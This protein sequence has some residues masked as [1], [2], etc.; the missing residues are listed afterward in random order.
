MSRKSPSQSEERYVPEAAKKAETP[1]AGNMSD[2]HP[3]TSILS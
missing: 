3:L 1:E 2:L